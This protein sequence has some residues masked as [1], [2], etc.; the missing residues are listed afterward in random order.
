MEKKFT[1]WEKK[2]KGHK[3]SVFKVQTP[4]PGVSQQSALAF[5]MA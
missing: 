2:A 4:N 5:S 3:R 1:F